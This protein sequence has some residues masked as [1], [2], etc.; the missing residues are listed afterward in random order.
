ML[1]QQ[2]F[3][4]REL[5]KLSYCVVR[6]LLAAHRHKNTALER[7]LTGLQLCTLKLNL[8]LHDKIRLKNPDVFK[9]ETNTFVTVISTMYGVRSNN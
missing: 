1:F 8:Q 2:N 6:S 4:K 7:Y 9:K 3:Q 5:N